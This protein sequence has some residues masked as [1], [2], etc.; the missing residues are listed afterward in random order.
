MLLTSLAG[1]AVVAGT[2]AVAA[3][4]VAGTPASVVVVVAGT[5]ASVVGTR[6]DALPAQGPWPR[7]RRL[8]RSPAGGP[9]VV[10][11]PWPR[12]QAPGGG[13]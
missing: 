3:V 1:V 7:L 8:A 6:A 9:L 5:P 10:G 12:R 13:R 4:V 11:Q 2:P